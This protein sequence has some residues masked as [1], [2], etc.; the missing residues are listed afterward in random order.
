M[1]WKIP[2]AH[3]ILKFC[4]PNGYW[5]FSVFSISLKYMVTAKFNRA[6][7]LQIQIPQEVTQMVIFENI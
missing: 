5:N 6:L 7:D 2:L 1:L 3:V 4:G